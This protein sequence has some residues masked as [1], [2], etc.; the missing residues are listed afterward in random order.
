MKNGFDRPQLAGHG[1]ARAE[2]AVGHAFVDMPVDD[3]DRDLAHVTD[4][5][6]QMQGQVR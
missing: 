6:R 1:Q 4:L 2:A 3:R 5:A